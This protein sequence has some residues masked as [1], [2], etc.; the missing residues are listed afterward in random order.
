MHQDVW[1]AWW[2]Y[3]HLFLS[4][5]LFVSLSWSAPLGSSHE[6]RPATSTH[7]G[8]LFLGYFDPS[9]TLLHS[10]LSNLPCPSSQRA[11]TTRLAPALY[12]FVTSIV[13]PRL[14]LA[15][16]TR[17]AKAFPVSR[18]QQLVQQAQPFLQDQQCTDSSLQCTCF[19]TLQVDPSEVSIFSLL[20]S[21]HSPIYF[22]ASFL[23]FFIVVFFPLSHIHWREAL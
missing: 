14:S 18:L 8:S 22:V 20:P 6:S 17:P 19:K 1:E 9:P 2:H 15:S 23:L 3:L 10:G 13:C 16:A 12:G 11:S 5:V 7:P 21:L 4:S